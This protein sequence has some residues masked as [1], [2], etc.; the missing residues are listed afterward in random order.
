MKLNILLFSVLSILFS[1][2]IKGEKYISM[3]PTLRLEE[4]FNGSVKLWGMVQDRSGNIVNRFDAS[5]DGRWDGKNG[6][7]DEIF[8]YYDSV[9]QDKRVWRITK[10]DN[11]HYEGYANDII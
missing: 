4:F 7:L 2:G 3:E 11:F 9:K 8:T 10:I 6:V 5:I 1:C